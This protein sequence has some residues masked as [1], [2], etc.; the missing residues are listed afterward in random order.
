MKTQSIHN[1]MNDKH[2]VF[3]N[4]PANTRPV[5]ESVLRKCVGDKE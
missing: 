3:V 5:R 2:S 1:T 4:I